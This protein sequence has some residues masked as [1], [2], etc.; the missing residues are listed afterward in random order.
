MGLVTGASSFTDGVG[1]TS[2]I[3]NTPGIGASAAVNCYNST[4][5]GV[6]AGTW[7]LPATCQMNG[8]GSLAS[9]PSGI[10][11]IDV[12]LVQLGFGGFL[13]GANIYYW[14]STEWSATPGNGAWAQHFGTGGGSYQQ[15]F[16]KSQGFN[17]RCAQS[18]TL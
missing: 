14:S 16:D 12:N 2:T 4:N 11:N 7:Y 6:I 10:A 8:S 9:C 3:V 15:G 1:N 13:T 5:G 18:L 17:V